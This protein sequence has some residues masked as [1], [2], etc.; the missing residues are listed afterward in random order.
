MKSYAGNSNSIADSI[1]TLLYDHQL[2][3][4]IVKN[5]KKKVKEEFGWNKIAQ[6]TYFAYQ[7]AICQTVAEKQANEI[8]QENAKK[9]KKAKNTD[10]E[11]TDLLAFKAKHAYA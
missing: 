8:A 4:N 6:D 9:T 2:A 5:A 1:L 11:I 7:K 3:A 10:A